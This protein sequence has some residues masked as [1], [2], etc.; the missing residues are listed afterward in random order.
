MVLPRRLARLNKRFLNRALVRIAPYPPGFAVLHHRGRRSGRRYSIPINVFV[1]DGRYVFA[2]TYGADTDWLRN[3]QAA[4]RC[5]I[6]T[7]GHVVA[8]H[9]PRVYRDEHRADMPLPARWILGLVGVDHF[10]E[11]QAAP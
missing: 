8:L 10:L 3:V 6:T 2:L 4:G 5:T 11:M 9:A 1:R 7:G